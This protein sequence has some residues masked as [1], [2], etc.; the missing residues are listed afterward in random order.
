L[1][2]LFAW[3][4]VQLQFTPLER[5]VIQARLRQR[6]DDDAKREAAL[7]VLFRESGCKDLSEQPVKRQKV[8]NLVC[9]LPG[10]VP[11]Q[12]VV[13]SHFDF[14]SRGHVLDNWSGASLLP[15]LYESLNSGQRHHTFVFVGFTDE[16]SRQIGSESY[17]K[18]LTSQQAGA[19]RAMVNLDT[20]GLAP[21]KVWAGHADP[22]LLQ[23]LTSAANSTG[24]PLQGV[25]TDSAGRT[26]SEPFRNAHIPAITIHSLTAD[27]WRVVHRTDDTMKVLRFDDYYATY[28]LVAVY[29]ALLDA[30]LE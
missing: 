14:S 18:N 24:S 21:T 28:R 2:L 19:V 8:P 22:R 13:G 4:Q 15:S 9:V 11:E 3:Q 17:V 25:N 6:G 10:E 20:L 23:L 12:I 27:T 26:D 1:L 7:K 29:L 5:P 16:E 30:K